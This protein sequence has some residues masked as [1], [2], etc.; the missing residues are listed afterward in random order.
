M[1]DAD[2]HFRAR[3][4]IVALVLARLAPRIDLREP[5]VG[6][7]FGTGRYF[8]CFINDAVLSVPAAVGTHARSVSS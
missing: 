7:S 3:R 8:R 5:F 6:R 4:E 1:F 2:L